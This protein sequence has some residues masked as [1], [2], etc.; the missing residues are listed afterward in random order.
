MNATCFLSPGELFP[1][2]GGL[3]D[4]VLPLKDPPAQCYAAP[5]LHPLS[6]CEPAPARSCKDFRMAAYHAGVSF[7]LSAEKAGK[8]VAHD[9]LDNW[10]GVA[11]QLT[12]VLH[13]VRYPLRVGKV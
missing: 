10:F 6:T 12:D 5:L 11:F 9:R 7:L 8:V 13:G 1:Q 2:V 4:R 3:I